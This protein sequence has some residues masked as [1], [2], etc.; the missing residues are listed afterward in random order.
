MS[1]F[2][3]KLHIQWFYS[4]E[5]GNNLG[6]EITDPVVEVVN[7]TL[8][9][10]YP[11]FTAEDVASGITKYRCLYMR[12]MHPT[13]PLKN[14][15][16]YIPINT[17]SPST[18][19][20][21]GV[22]PAGIGDG[23]TTGVATTIINENTAPDGVF[24]T[25]AVDRQ[26]GI[27]LRLNLPP[28]GKTVPV[29]FRL[30][31][32][33]NAQVRPA[34]YCKIACDSDNKADDIGIPAAPIDTTG[35]VIG[36]TDQNGNSSE[37]IDRYF[38]RDLD[39]L[40]FNGNVTTTGSPSWLINLLAK[41]KDFTLFGWG[42][43]DVKHISIRNQLTN[44]FSIGTS[45][46]GN[47]FHGHKINNMY[48]LIMDTSGFQSYEN[49]SAQYDYVVDKLDFASRDSD[50]DFILVSMND[51]MYGALPANDTS[52]THNDVLRRTYHKL[53]QDYGVH[54]VFQSRIRNYQNLGVLRYNDANTD[55]PSTLL[56]GPNYSITG[57]VKSFGADSGVLF[58]NVG[59]GGRTPFHSLGSTANYPQIH[60]SIPTVGGVFRWESKMRREGKPAKFTGA[61]YNYVRSNNDF[62]GFYVGSTREEKL[63][64]SWSISIE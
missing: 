26:N 10:L 41:L 30:K 56:S 34:D 24:F 52:Y 37:I 11:N 15:I 54:V 3:V 58:I 46:V 25:E 18:E 45:E 48:W 20:W 57:G 39:W 21:V 5:S 14:P 12:N 9:N 23:V 42:A 32:V 49:P 44:A 8:H 31:L 17:I 7:R 51:T 33:A 27:P 62:F 40:I 59:S 36:E 50:I 6:G 16:F 29:W 61:Y 22:D 28:N 64:D 4:G 35:G 55:V 53:F 47:G 38:L 43:E 2:D 19:I 63:V 13:V 1:T 60:A